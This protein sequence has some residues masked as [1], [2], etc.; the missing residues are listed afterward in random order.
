MAGNA[1]QMLLQYNAKKQL[2]QCI[3]NKILC[4]VLQNNASDQL[5]SIGWLAPWCAADSWNNNGSAGAATALLH[6][7]SCPLKMHE[8]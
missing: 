2:V 8:Y 5:T 3:E 7:I 1:C 4:T 6:F